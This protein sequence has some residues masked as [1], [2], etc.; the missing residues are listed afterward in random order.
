MVVTTLTRLRSSAA[1]SR[2]PR[3]TLAAGGTQRRPSVRRAADYRSAPVSGTRLLRTGSNDV[4]VVRGHDHE[5]LLPAIDSVIVRVDV[6][7]RTMVVQPL[8]GMLNE[9]G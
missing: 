4:Y 7:A 1:A 8:P 3:R 5:V 6:A 2:L 9:E